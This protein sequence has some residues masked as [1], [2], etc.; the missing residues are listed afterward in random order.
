MAIEDMAEL[1]ALCIDKSGTLTLDKLEFKPNGEVEKYKARLVAKGCTQM[2]GVDYHDTFAPV[3][4]L[5]TVR[6]LLTVAVKRDWIIH[7][8][9]VNN[10]F[11]H[12]CMLDHKSPVLEDITVKDLTI[13][14][15]LHN[16]TFIL[17]GRKLVLRYTFGRAGTVRANLKLG[18]YVLE[19][20]DL[21]ALQKQSDNKMYRLRLTWDFKMQLT[22]AQENKDI[23]IADKLNSSLS[24]SFRHPVRGGEETQQFDELS[25]ILA[26][27]SLS[28]LDDRWFWDLSGDGTFQVKGVRSLLDETFLPK[29]DTPTWWIKNGGTWKFIL[30]NPI[31]VGFLGSNLSFLDLSCKIFWKAGSMFLGGAF[32]MEKAK[33]LPLQN[34]F[35]LLQQIQQQQQSFINSSAILRPP[36]HHHHQSTQAQMACDDAW[37]VCHPDFKQPFSSLEDACQRGFLEFLT[38]SVSFRTS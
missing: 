14:L 4:K 38:L 8:L 17:E 6:T 34:Q 29:M 13:I 16:E 24:S 32:E 15:D 1:D 18:T 26:S 25:G 33:A 10:A 35:R 5:V 7:Q 23:L 19:G 28:S 20:A 36:D 22:L 30:M 2:E 11:L 3:A 27:A 9:D 37:H 21:R 31:M 12:G